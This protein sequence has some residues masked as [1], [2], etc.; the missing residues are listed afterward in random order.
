M[1]IFYFLLPAVL[2]G[3]IIYYIST[4]P[5]LPPID[6]AGHIE[7]SPGS[8]LIDEPMPEPIQKHMLEHADGQGKPG[9]IIQYNCQK[10]ICEKNL[11]NNLQKLVKKY[12]ENVYLTPGKY[13]GKIILT[14]IGKR[15]I[16]KKY[17]EKKIITFINSF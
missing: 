14:K 12:P 17:D 2:I 13:D 8:H 15:E 16:L 6:L 11:V 5:H 10:Y 7:E 9:I 3:A 1:K 4:Q